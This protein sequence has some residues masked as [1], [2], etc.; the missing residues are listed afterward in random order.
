MACRHMPLQVLGEGER[1]VEW[2]AWGQVGR[3]SEDQCWPAQG[4]WRVTVGA[5]PPGASSA[6]R[7]TPQV[8]QTHFLV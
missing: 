4:R 2:A 3:V 5:A 6:F 1:E 7:D 8:S